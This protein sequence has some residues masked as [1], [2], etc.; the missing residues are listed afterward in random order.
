MEKY[1]GG[2]A[3]G[4]VSFELSD[5]PSW[6]I[7]CHCN[8]CKKRTGSDY[9]VSVMTP[10]DNVAEFIGKTAKFTR[11]G[12]SGGDVHYEFCPEC[13]TTVRWKVSFLT[14]REAFAGGAFDDI[15]HL[16][17]VGEMYTAFKAPWP[18][19]SRRVCCE[20]APDDEVRQVWMAASCQ[21]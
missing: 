15:S 1:R 19:S 9:G 5:R 6:V 3:C 21:S 7:A 12:D 11:K 20:L 10:S 4:K 2:C 14:G 8:E 16:D 18:Q 17:L 13:G